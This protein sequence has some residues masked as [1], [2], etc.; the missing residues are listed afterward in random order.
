M[1][2]S[3]DRWRC[4]SC[5][6]ICCCAACRRREMRDKPGADSPP[7]PTPVEPPPKP[8]KAGR[9]GHHQS[10]QQQQREQHQ[11]HLQQQAAAAAAAQQQHQHHHLQSHHHMSGMAPSG[12]IGHIGAVNPL[13][14]LTPSNGPMTATS[15]M[16]H[17]L[18]SS[19]PKLSP[20]FAPQA[21]PRLSPSRLVA[22]SSSGILHT[23][24]RLQA[25]RSGMTSPHMHMSPP[26]SP[27]PHMS[28]PPA[29]GLSP[30][31]SPKMSPLHGSSAFLTSPSP[32]LL[33]LTTPG[34]KP[35]LHSTGLS[36]SGFQRPSS[37]PPAFSLATGN[38]GGGDSVAL[39]GILS[40]AAAAA[41][42]EK[43]NNDH[44]S[45]G[46]HDT[47]AGSSSSTPGESISSTATVATN[48]SGQTTHTTT[49]TSRSPSLR[50]SISGM[51]GTPSSFFLSPFT[52]SLLPGGSPP[53]S[54][55]APPPL[56]TPGGGNAMRSVSPSPFSIHSP[57]LTA[58]LGG[59]SSIPSTLTSISSSTLSSTSSSAGSGNNNSNISNTLGTSMSNS[60]S[61]SRGGR[62]TSLSTSVR[63]SGGGSL[64]AARQITASLHPYGAS[65]HTT[66]LNVISGGGQSAPLPVAS[67]PEFDQNNPMQAMSIIFAVSAC[68]PTSMLAS[69]SLYHY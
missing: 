56:R 29:L 26:L 66:I 44:I 32:S 34:L 18:P 39:T 5:R 54:I 55:F 58:A 22:S 4:P 27:A 43:P 1:T 10:Q 2:I 60:S 36:P 65:P 69:S 35:G 25:M 37:S 33:K 31:M 53:S 11:H 12:S 40:L 50:A 61:S 21:S 57:A 68:S 19:S 7:G 47:I 52:S 16:L 41:V 49:I 30:K 24:P 9:G 38:E 3:C 48:S 23:S 51:P 6:R 63:N 20:T 28:P 8:V 14:P 17:S 45:N 67:P 15:P 42:S 59:M 64:A 13:A 46:E 62:S